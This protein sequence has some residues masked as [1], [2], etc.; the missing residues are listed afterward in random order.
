MKEERIYK[1][2]DCKDIECQINLID[3][4]P[5]VSDEAPTLCQYNGRKADW[6]TVSKE[7]LKDTIPEET[8]L[9]QE[10]I[11]LICW[12]RLRD[13][14]H[15]I[16]HLVELISE[17]GVFIRRQYNQVILSYGKLYA[18][19]EMSTNLQTWEPCRKGA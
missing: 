11:S 10:D 7:I 1:C 12:V 13:T 4:K 9:T 16:P 5:Y 8:E 18:R 19:Y 14:K 15:A 2:N 6:R 17:T 3:K